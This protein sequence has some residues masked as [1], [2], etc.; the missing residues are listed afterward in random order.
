MNLKNKRRLVAR[1]L[2]V[3][4][5]RVI[6]NYEM[7]DEIKEAIT[8]QDIK[9]LLKERII[10]IREKKGKKSRKKRKTK[11]KEGKVKKKVN[12]RKKNYVKLTR[13]F[14]NYIKNLRKAGKITKE[15][16]SNLRKKIKMKAFKDLTH[17]REAIQSG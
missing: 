11:R 4:L 13:K 8:R 2:G 7:K 17:L 16:Y 1:M 10:K 12:R 3:G 6:L 15:K 5:D 9:D 14:R